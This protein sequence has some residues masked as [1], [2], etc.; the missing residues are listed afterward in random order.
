MKKGWHSWSTSCSRRRDLANVGAGTGSIWRVT[1]TRPAVVRPTSCRMPGSTGITSSKVSTKT[2]P[3]TGSYANRLRATCCLRRMWR[4][5]RRIWLRRDFWSWAHETTL[6]DDAITFHMD[7]ID[8]QVDTVGRV[9]LGMTI[10]CA[11]CHDHKFDPIPATDYYALAGIFQSTRTAKQIAGSKNY[12][13]HTVADPRE[14]NDGSRLAAH[15]QKTAE[16]RALSKQVAE[17]QRAIEAVRGGGALPAAE[18]SL[19]KQE[20]IVRS[21]EQLAERRL[22]LQASRAQIPGKPAT[23]MGVR[24]AA[25]PVSARLRIRGNP[26]REGPIVPRGFLTL[27]AHTMPESVVRPEFPSNQSG[28][29]QLADWVVAR[30]NPLTMRVFVNR[31]WH[32]LFGRGIVTT[33]D[34]FGTT[35]SLPSHP[36]LLDWLVER[37]AANEYSLKGLI[38]TIV[39]TRSYRLGTLRPRRGDEKLRAADPENSLFGRR[40]RRSLDAESVRDC[41]LSISGQLNSRIGGPSFGDKISKEYLV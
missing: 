31:V 3:T 8:E 2:S 25:T 13:W 32:H 27:V 6:R 30:E 21:E 28:R 7:G 5:V 40:S 9:F 26:H 36:A 10:G 17:L 22:S 11:R 24:C 23:F 19:S 38:R 33:V 34:N 41:I 20:W 4:S 1:R 14:D 15:E 37:F 18:D 39:L 29:L 12:T 35:G 16:S